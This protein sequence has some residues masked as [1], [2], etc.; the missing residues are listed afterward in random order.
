MSGN[1]L[2]KFKDV[3]YGDWA[4]IGQKLEDAGG[5]GVIGRIK[6]DEVTIVIEGGWDY[7]FTSP[8]EQ[9]G[10]ILEINEVV[11]K[12]LAITEAAIHA[13]GDPPMC[14]PSDKN[15][16]YCVNLLFESGD[17]LNTFRYN[18][19]ACRFTLG[20]LRTWKWNGLLFTPKGV[21]QRDGA[22]PRKPGLRW[23]VAE[24]GRQFKDQ[25]VRD[26]RP[27]LKVMGMGQELPLIAALH[28]KWAVS[29]DG[30]NIPFVDAPD[31]DVAPD[32]W[33]GFYFAPYLNFNRGNRRVDL[34]AGRVDLP[35]SDCGSGSLL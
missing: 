10:R 17:T 12:N 24:L 32:A 2:Q 15:N 28:P 25:C 20:L 22:I 16:L 26:V 14:P 35:D 11:W 21:K 29:M 6:R 31:L 9:I 8:E 4:C 19:E 3:P 23:Q 34:G 1:P 30:D 27:Q 33:G 13:L 18:W 7:N 5:E